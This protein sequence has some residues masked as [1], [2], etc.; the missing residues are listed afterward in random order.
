M[1]ETSDS[2]AG[3]HTLFAG[4]QWQWT[5]KIN[6]GADVN[7]IQQQYQDDSPGPDRDEK[8]YS[9]SPLQM[10]Y[11]FSDYF[12]IRLDTRWVDRDSPLAYRTYTS[13]QAIL[14]LS[15]RY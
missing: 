15:F 11:Q 10:T 13:S 3:T 7:Y 9:A 5:P 1:G 12:S 4:V 14:G 6:V 2:P 8:V